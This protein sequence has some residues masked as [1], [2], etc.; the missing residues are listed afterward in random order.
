MVTGAKPPRRSRSRDQPGFWLTFSASIRLHKI[1][2][3]RVGPT[4][5]C[6][7]SRRFCVKWDHDPSDLNYPSRYGR[8]RFSPDRTQSGRRL[9]T[10][11]YGQRRLSRR[12]QDFR[13][14]RR[15]EAG[16]W[17]SNA[18]AR[19][20]TGI[21][22]RATCGFPCR[23]WRMGQKRRNPRASRRG[24]QG[25]SRRRTPHRMETAR[26]EECGYASQQQQIEQREDHRA[27]TSA[28]KNKTAGP[29]PCRSNFR[30]NFTYLPRLTAFFRSAPAVNFAT[31]RAAILR[32]APVCGLRPLR[33]FRCET[34]NVPNP[35]K[36][37]RS[38]FFRALVMLSTVVSI[39]VAA[40]VL[41]TPQPDAIRSM[42]SALFMLAP[43]E[44]SFFSAIFSP[45]AER[46]AIR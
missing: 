18:H 24:G 34:E 15:R 42:R 27:L 11:A 2:H 39:A 36:A 7:T 16:L 32:V 10:F 13:H 8:Q 29:T 17:Q 41:L 46:S 25:R 26:R 12:W 38:P 5:G 44:V 23:S 21:R 14:S 19:T 9:R 45:V 40:W 31:R 6:P 33:A 37:T 1:K 43:G 30:W 20:T 28:P 4:L 22:R 35:I 3:W